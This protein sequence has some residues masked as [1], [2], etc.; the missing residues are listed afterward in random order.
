MT[1]STLLEIVT[2]KY[3]ALSGER[4]NATAFRPFQLESFKELL[5]NVYGYQDDGTEQMFSGITGEAIPG[6]IMIGPSYYQLLRHQVKAKMH[7][8][9]EGPKDQVTGQALEGRQKRGGIRIGEMEV[10]ALIEHGAAHFLR[11]RMF[12]ASDPYQGVFCTNCQTMTSIDV[13]EANPGCRTCRTD[14]VA[15][16][17]IPQTFKSLLNI[18]ATAGINIRMLTRESVVNPIQFEDLDNYEYDSDD[19]LTD[20]GEAEQDDEFINE[21]EYEINSELLDV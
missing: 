15:S 7:V 10:G 19:L 14:Q 8:R 13:M 6:N 9:G 2:S 4:I 11:E 1:I 3:G 18:A 21:E 16:C 5:R 12:T 20:F 17:Q